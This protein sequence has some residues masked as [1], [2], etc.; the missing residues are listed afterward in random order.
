MAQHCYTPLSMEH[1]KKANF[2]KRDFFVCSQG[3][4]IT[5]RLQAQGIV[6][7]M[8]RDL[9]K[10]SEECSLGHPWWPSG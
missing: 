5:T 9:G 7:L 6:D 8:L 1:F 3:S 4:Q 10:G 2:L